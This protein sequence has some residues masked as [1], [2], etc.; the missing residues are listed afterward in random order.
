MPQC[1]FYWSII[2]Y[3]LHVHELCALIFTYCSRKNNSKQSQDDIQHDM[4]NTTCVFQYLV[5][6]ESQFQY[7]EFGYICNQNSINFAAILCTCNQH[8]PKLPITKKPNPPPLREKTTK[9][10][11]CHFWGKD[12]QK[13][14]TKIIF[15]SQVSF[16][17]VLNWTTCTASF[18]SVLSC[19][20]T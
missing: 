18:Y 17:S 8:E 2:I 5:C 16:I 15:P 20:R 7:A 10:H 4:C 6:L 12:I 9:K 1:H 11:L 3:N 13:H 14:V 19:D